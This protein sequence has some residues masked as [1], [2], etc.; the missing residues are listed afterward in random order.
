MA[1]NDID[2]FAASLL[3][4][5]K[6]FLEKATES[7]DVVEAHLH[8]A[9]MLGFCALEAYVNSIADDFSRARVDL[10][11]ADKGVLLEKDLRLEHG[12]FKLGGL[13]MYRLEDRILFLHQRF[14]V[15]PLDRTVTAWSELGSALNLRNQLT[16]PRQVPVIAVGQVERAL[17]SIVDT[18]DMLFRALYKRPFPAAGRRLQSRLD[19]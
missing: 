2:D 6:R 4:E 3:E 10:A 8:A 19:F 16:H 11:P 15:E 14:A 1:A 13:K 5:A 17:Q 7:G 12:E 9:L 18:L